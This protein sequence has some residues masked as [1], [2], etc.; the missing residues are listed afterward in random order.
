MN[1]GLVNI[2]INHLNEILLWFVVYLMSSPF[3][4]D[5]ICF[6]NQ[7]CILVIFFRK[8]IKM[9]LC[10]IIWNHNTF[11]LDCATINK[12]FIITVQFLLLLLAACLF[13]YYILIIFHYY[14][15]FSGGS[16]SWESRKLN[17]LKQWG[18][19]SFVFLVWIPYNFFHHHFSYFSCCSRAHTPRMLILSP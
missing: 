14:F 6:I 12:P 3:Y 13:D 16:P 7:K 11:N 15:F 8:C 4:G 18:K 5:G 10:F 19:V 9:Y 1:V 2:L 17:Y